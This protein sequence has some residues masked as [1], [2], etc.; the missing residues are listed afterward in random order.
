MAQ[1]PGRQPSAVSLAP[2]WLTDRPLAEQLWAEGSSSVT[3]G[4]DAVE[5]ARPLV[6]RNICLEHA[7]RPNVG[8]APQTELVAAG[9]EPRWTEPMADRARTVHDSRPLSHD[10]RPHSAQVNRAHGLQSSAGQSLWQTAPR[11][12]ELV[13][14][15]THGYGV[16]VLTTQWLFCRQYDTAAVCR[17]GKGAGARRRAPATAFR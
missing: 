8:G 4:A 7:R 11:R 9:T 1:A 12:T 17:T 10:S 16:A 14:R 2:P 15:T 6:L 3:G 13:A 5:G